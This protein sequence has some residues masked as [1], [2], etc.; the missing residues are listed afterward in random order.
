M[1]SHRRFRAIIL[2]VSLV[3][4]VAAAGFFA[5][6]GTPL[7]PMPEA[8]AALD[9]GDRVEVVQGD[10][11]VFRP[12]GAPPHTGLI[13]YPGGRVDPRAYAPPARAI[14]ER[15]YLVVIVPM[16]LNL[17]VFGAGR[18]VDVMHAHPEIEHWVVGGH[19]LGGAMAARFAHQH[20]GAV[21]GLVL[22]AAYSA[23]G[24]DLSGQPLAAVSVIGS[25]DGLGTGEGAEAG[26]GR[27]PASTRWIV[28]AGG[29]HAQFGWYGEQPGDE[30][31][32]I[33]RAEQ[34]A[35]AVGAT[36]VLLEQ[37]Q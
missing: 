36:L 10:W 7:A 5:W 35:Q 14:A 19:S 22:W 25:R 26:R 30:P 24:D 18:A 20:P 34:Q 13:W 15:G 11:I 29:N 28:I 17:A 16:P 21:D 6:A 32:G 9:T 27:L 31:A 1:K 33:S 4:A 12:A 3:L 37:V 23:G 2:V 8:L